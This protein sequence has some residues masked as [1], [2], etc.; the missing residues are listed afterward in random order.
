MHHRV[1]AIGPRPAALA[2][3]VLSWVTG[4]IDR[5][6]DRMK[7]RHSS[8]RVAVSLA[9]GL[10]FVLADLA[11]QHGIGLEVW[12]PHVQIGQHWPPDL[13][14]RLYKTIDSA[15]SLVVAHNEEK[16]QP[17]MHPSHLRSLA[18][19][20]GSQLIVTGASDL[21][22]SGLCTSRTYKI[23]FAKRRVSWSQT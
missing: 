23:D 3:P 11:V 17:W 18:T 2:Q 13:K 5:A 20:A 19:S 6:L 1:A 16:F 9:P 4:E 7:R 14:G 15:Q 22:L 12:V 21:D 10:G 8:L